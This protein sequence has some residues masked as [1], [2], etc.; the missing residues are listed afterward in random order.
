MSQYNIVIESKEVTV[1]SEYTPDKGRSTDYQ[2]ESSLEQDFI[3]RLGE[4]G[5]EYLQIH[6]EFELIMNLRK[7]LETLNNY[8]FSDAEW[9]KFFAQ[10]ISSANEG[11]VEKTRKIQDDHVQNQ[12]GR[13][14]C[15][16]RV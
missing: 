3:K 7:Q 12:I 16:E 1:V 11:I 10:T 5:Y 14:S 2:S 8:K 9:S 15:R 6:D 4:Q 13:A